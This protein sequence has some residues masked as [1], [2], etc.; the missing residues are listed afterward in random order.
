MVLYKH[1]DGPKAN[2]PISTN[3]YFQLQKDILTGKLKNGQKLTEQAI[4]RRI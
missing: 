2:V 1:S 4:L 3:L